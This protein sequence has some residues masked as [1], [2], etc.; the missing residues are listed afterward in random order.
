MLVLV[1]VLV[2]VLSHLAVVGMLTVI[3]SGGQGAL[4]SASCGTVGMCRRATCCAE[5][6]HV[7]RGSFGD[8]P[9]G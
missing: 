3:R 6:L 2:L 4:W 7:G 5:L 8:D 9:R 1:L